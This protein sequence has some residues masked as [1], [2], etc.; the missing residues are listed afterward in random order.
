MLPAS[1]FAF[2]ALLLSFRRSF[3]VALILGAIIV[4]VLVRGE[5]RFKV[6]VPAVLVF[7]VVFAAGLASFGS[8][9]GVSVP[10]PVVER[11]RELNPSSFNVSGND[12]Y[13]IAERANVLNDLRYHVTLGR[14]V[15]TPWR[16]S[17]PVR[18]AFEGSRTYVHMAVLAHWLKFGIL[19]VIAYV[20]MIAALM[21]AAYRSW[22]RADEALFRIGALA[23]L[24]A[25]I[26][27]VSADLTASF[28]N[29]NL[30]LSFLVALAMGWLAA[31]RRYERA[32]DELAT[33]PSVPVAA[34]AG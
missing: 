16:A 9:G 28:T 17:K 23:L 30:R 19:G 6:L 10:T 22:L 8:L 26:G 5:R 1:T 33:G 4:L 24:G 27:L 12:R 32:D 25:T 7:G 34:R 2:L 13:R 15:A 3:W 18:G 14:G 11:A 31:V 29:S 21:Y 20:W